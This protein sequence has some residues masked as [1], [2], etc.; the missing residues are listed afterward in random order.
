MWEEKENMLIL[1]L[2]SSR[3]YNQHCSYIK[4]EASAR[5]LLAQFNIKIMLSESKINFNMSTCYFKSIYTD[6]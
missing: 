3:W 1:F 2:G 6:I 5:K 4:K